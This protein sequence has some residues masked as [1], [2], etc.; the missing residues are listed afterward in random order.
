MVA[1]YFIA[2]FIYYSSY[3]LDWFNYV[4]LYDVE[5]YWSK[6]IGTR[7]NKDNSHWWTKCLLRVRNEALS[8]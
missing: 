8:A 1:L 2:Y 5:F 7:E 6:S 3:Y 4:L